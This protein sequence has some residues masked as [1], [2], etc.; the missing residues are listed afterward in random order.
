VVKAFKELSVPYKVLHT[1]QHYD[2]TMSEIHFV[3]LNLAE[4]DFNLEIGSDSHA[5]QTARMLTGMEEVFISEKPAL[6]LVYGDTN[7]TLAG[8]LCAAKLGIKV[9]HVEAGVRSYDRKMPEE[10]NRIV[11]DHLSDHHFCPTA[12]AVKILKTE[13][14]E[15]ILTGDVMYDALLQVPEENLRHPYQKP[16]VLATIHRAENTDSKERFTAIWEGLN[17]VSREIRVVFPVHLRTR[18]MY[19]GLL[20]EHSGNIVVT[21]PVS[22][23]EM[24]AMTRDALCVI[25]DSGGV[26]KEAFLLGSPCVTVRDVTEWPETVEANANRLVNADAEAISHA[27]RTM[28]KQGSSLKANPFGDG[29]ASYKIARHISEHCL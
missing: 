7:S 3:S 29:S 25:T 8:A 9:G 26:Q 13:G 20:E 10:I 16:F 4:P 5:R 23:L 15:G 1:G 27:V 17:L 18:N 6:V 14:I 11:A 22:Y 28:M 2:Y 24:I 21:D 12:N 19:R